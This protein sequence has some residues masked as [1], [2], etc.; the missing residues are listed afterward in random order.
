LHSCYFKQKNKNDNL[1]LLE[2]FLSQNLQKTGGIYAYLF[3]H[4]QSMGNH[5]GTIVGWTDT[6]LSVKGR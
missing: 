2:N 6:K 5:A 3:R 4:G 1:T